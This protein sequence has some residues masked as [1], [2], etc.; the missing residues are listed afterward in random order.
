MESY[1]TNLNFAEIREFSLTK[2]T[3]WGEIGR[4]FGLYNL[5]KNMGQIF[6]KSGKFLDFGT[7]V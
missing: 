7:V 3:I 4:V 6:E 5:T 1:F 2:P